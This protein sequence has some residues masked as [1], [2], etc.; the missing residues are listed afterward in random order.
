MPMKKQLAPQVR[1]LLT[2][3]AGQGRQ[4]LSEVET[5]LVQTT[6]LLDEAIEK[7]GASFMAIHAAVCAQQEAVNQLLSSGAQAQED[8]ARIKHMSGEIG[9]HV[10]SAVTGLQFQDMTSQLIGR[11]VRRVTGLREVVGVLDTASAGM[12]AEADVGEV[13]E[14]LRI[15]NEVVVTQSAKLEG[16]LWKPVQQTH[17]ESGDIELF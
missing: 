7:L 16:L 3:V 2:E 8:V 5:D 9:R 1:R 4:H 15:L 10:N 17:M 6:V 14:M 11:T 13:V 12:Q